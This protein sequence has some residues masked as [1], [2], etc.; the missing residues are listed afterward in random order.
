MIDVPVIT[1]ITTQ[2]NQSNRYNIYIDKGQGETY[3]FSVDEDVL[4]KY[5]LRKGRSLDE[6]ILQAI[7]NEDHFHQLYTK[8]V[9]YL[10]YRMRTE[11]EIRHYLTKNG[12]DDE[13][14]EKIIQRLLDK[15]YLND[16]EFANMFVRSRMQTSLKGPTLVKN[17]LM[18]KGVVS[19]IAEEAVL[20]YH[21]DVQKDLIQKIIRKKLRQTKKQ[22]FRSLQQRLLMTC[23]R[24]G[25]SEYLVREVLGEMG[26]EMNK[27]EEW[28]AI[29]HHGERLLKRYGQKH[30]SYELQQRIKMGLYRRGFQRE[31]IEKY[32]DEHVR[33]V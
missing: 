6:E 7:Q 33:N 26:D 16:R 23:L 5:H 2:K 30:T 3:G 13:V 15:G 4:I 19:H 12:A 17:E 10:S 31:H 32:I 1:R 20:A 28:A 9:R 24:Q 21:E 22:S 8:A 11:Q 18:A 14:S 25:F 29:L 27:D